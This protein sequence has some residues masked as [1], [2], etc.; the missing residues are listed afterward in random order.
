MK[1]MRRVQGRPPARLRMGCPAAGLAAV[2]PGLAALFA[3]V[4]VI[5]SL[6]SLAAMLRS[7][8]RGA[9]GPGGLPRRSR[10]PAPAR[11]PLPVSYP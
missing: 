8:G 2:A 7:G 4:L 1:R 9:F 3:V 6:S 5:V 10:K 11:G